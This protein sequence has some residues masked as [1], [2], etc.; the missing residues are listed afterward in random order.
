M[1]NCLPDE[2][3][4]D[5]DDN[6]DVVY[7]QSLYL[8]L[9]SVHAGGGS[10]LNITQTITASSHDAPILHVFCATLS[11]FSRTHI[12]NC[13]Q[14]I[15]SGTK[16]VITFSDHVEGG[17]EHDCC[18]PGRDVRGMNCVFSQQVRGRDTV[19]RVSRKMASYFLR[20]HQ[21]VAIG[22]NR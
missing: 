8:K 22:T 16:K 3:D 12:S 15:G 18:W 20:R 4:D 11:R 2:D 7:S 5:G 9:K 10:A 1:P 17:C 19:F 21:I 13:G 14:R 6:N